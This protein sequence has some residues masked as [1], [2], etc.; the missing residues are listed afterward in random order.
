M[1]ERSGSTPEQELLDLH[2]GLARASAE[3]GKARA[4]AALRRQWQARP[5]LTAAATTSAVAVST[6]ATRSPAAGRARGRLAATLA[7]FV[8]IA[9]RRAVRG[10][11][12]ALAG[13][14]S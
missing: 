3:L 12:G 14:R 11:L 9:R 5:V 10:A 7:V 4:R 8:R 6:W 13:R 2:A 1:G